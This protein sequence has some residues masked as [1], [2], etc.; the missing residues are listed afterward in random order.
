MRIIVSLLT[1][2]LAAVM[3][4]SRTAASS[5]LTVPNAS[6]ITIS[7]NEYEAESGADG[8]AIQRDGEVIHFQMIPG[9][10]W[11]PE[12]AGSDGER[13]ELDGY[14][15]P[16]AFG[17]PYWLAGSFYWDPG[18]VS[19]SDWLAFLQ[20]H[21]L[22]SLM[23]RKGRGTMEW[24]LQAPSG[25]PPLYSRPLTQGKWY[26]VVLQVTMDPANG[27]LRSWLDG[28]E[29]VNYKGAV[30]VHGGHGYPK[31]GIYRG[32][33]ASNGK[34]VTESLGLR[35]ANFKAGTTDLSPLISRPDPIPPTSPWP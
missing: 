12:D 4:V 27:N 1:L 8:K 18:P 23:A 16:L 32:K 17:S 22:F 21:S 28:E 26:N 10:A 34:P 14:K 29:V 13:A 31:I 24:I 2:V 6:K 20:L 9:N 33:L 25:R 7:G 5:W 35:W 19:T 3:I 15:R 30:G 11:L